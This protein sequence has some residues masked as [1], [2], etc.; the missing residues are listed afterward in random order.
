MGK[1]TTKKQAQQEQQQVEQAARFAAL[2]RAAKA[3]KPVAPLLEGFEPYRDRFARDPDAFELKTRSR[4]PFKACREMARHLFARY[5]VPPVL[6]GVWDPVEPRVQEG[7][8][9]G[10][11]R[12]PPAPRV[13]NPND[14]AI[15]TKAWYIACVQGQ[16]LHKAYA[17]PWFTQRE[18]HLFVTA[19]VGLPVYATFV[20][21]WAKAA[22]AS[23]GLA[24][25]LARTRLSERRFSPFWRDVVRFFATAE[26]PPSKIEKIDDLLDFLDDRRRNDPGFSVFGAGHT[27]ASLSRRMVDWHRALARAKALGNDR[28]TG[29]PWP[30]DQWPEHP[31]VPDG[32]SW[33]MQQIL[34]AKDL[35]A[36]GTAQHHCVLSY[37]WK[38]REGRGS[39]WSLRYRAT[40]Y[41]P[42]RRRLT[43][44]L[45]LNGRPVQVR[46]FGNRLARSEETHQLNRWNARATGR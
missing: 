42:W 29:H 40:S 9:R 15:D 12:P 35:A 3:P 32:S 8:G 33:S 13:A 6:E 37:A 28:W 17:K 20:Y 7:R 39:I 25:R 2:G 24:L 27:V 26:P 38:C 36:E 19:K 43:V 21:V 18:T 10:F 41:E 30:D 22:G 31:D 34:N 1:S 46:G 16:S 44:E 14:Q 5:P 45:D 11:Y 23:E 4:A